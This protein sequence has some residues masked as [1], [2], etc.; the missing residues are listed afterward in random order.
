M[1]AHAEAR[2]TKSRL[3]R[4]VGSTVSRNRVDASMTTFPVYAPLAPVYAAVTRVERSVAAG[5][6]HGGRASA[7][8]CQRRRRGAGPL[9][10]N[11]EFRAIDYRSIGL[12]AGRLGRVTLP[13]AADVVDE[14]VDVL[15]EFRHDFVRLRLGQ[16]ARRDAL[17]KIGL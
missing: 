3:S 10:S 14:F 1:A 17:V 8:A 5:W 16:L 13:F 11:L 15:V 4:E 9:A 6:G 12:L 7:E 2:Q